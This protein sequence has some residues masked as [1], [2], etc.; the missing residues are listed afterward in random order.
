MKYY[1][2]ESTID[3]KERKF[4]SIVGTEIIFEKGM[5]KEV[6]VGELKEGLELKRDNF[7]PNKAF[8]EV[9][10]GV[11]SREIIHDPD[12]VS[13]AE[14]IKEGYVYVI[15]KRVGNP[16]GNINT[17]DII[18]AIQVAKGS[19]VDNSYHGNPNYCLLTDE[20]LFQLSDTLETGLLKELEKIMES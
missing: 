10:H 1:V 11:I 19:P 5:K 4:I 6:I 15:D 9:F 12:A 20:G 2:Y 7:I 8:L 18:G 14:K 13:E 3:E 16:E 17:E